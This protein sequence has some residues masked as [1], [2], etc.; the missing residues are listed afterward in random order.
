LG[1]FDTNVCGA[2]RSRRIQAKGNPN[3]APPLP[4][5]EVQPRRRAGH[6]PV[7]VQAT[8]V[9]DIP[10]YA[11]RKPLDVDPRALEDLA[12]EELSAGLGALNISGGGVDEPEAC[13]PPILTDCL[14][15]EAW[16]QYTLDALEV[17]SMPSVCCDL[18]VIDL[19]CLDLH[20]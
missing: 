15:A 19:I 5:L 3:L 4:T 18:H 20:V 17:I 2:R 11:Y 13:E 9:S 12:E 6:E 10:E 7:V 16:E 8:V 1:A 14:G